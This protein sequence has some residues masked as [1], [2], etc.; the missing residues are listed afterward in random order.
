MRIVLILIGHELKRFANDKTALTL[1][2]LVPV[3]LI[4]IFG[5]VFGV[6]RSSSGPTGIP[7]AVVR[8]ADSPASAAILAALQ[9]EKAFKVITTQPDAKG[10]E[11]PLT[12]ARLRELMRS[13]S[14][15]FALIFPPDAQGDPVV[16][17]KL[18]FLQNPRNEVEAQTVT[19]LVQKTIFTSAPQALLA[20]LP[21][22][23]KQFIGEEGFDRFSRQL[24]KSV[25]AAFGGDEEE[26]RQK[27]LAG[28]F[29]LSPN[30]PSGGSGFPLGAGTDLLQSVLRI[31][32]EQVAGV[33]VK[34]PQATRNVGGWAMMFLLFSLTAAAGS[35]FAEKKAG[36]FQRLLAAPVRRTH[37]LW[38]KY[39]YGMLLGLVQLGALFLTGRILFGLDL[40]SNWHNLFLICLAASAACVAFG[41]LLAAISPTAAAANGLG[42][43]FIL[44]MS[45][46]GGAW[47]PTTFMPE[48]IQKLSKLTIVYWS[49][50][51][52]LQV[53]WA[54]CTT[55]ELL[56]ILG[57]LFGVAAV[58]N[59]FSVWRFNRGEMF[60]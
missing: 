44:T 39:L 28:Q 23:G 17:L 29:D 20:S 33:N 57:I 19:G 49:I 38:S 58:V 10:V 32:S 42:T 5:Q 47:F 11:Q 27:L 52:F 46:I 21:K 53:L 16:G 18:K 4:Y 34:N 9:K 3:M 14:P 15:R 22:L 26:V 31:D 48:F 1:T 59:A 54:G 51:G 37:I 45:A 40:T 56:P 35:L 30:A 6:G 12:E 55:Y 24:A 50:E 7:L 41:M 25:A 8:Q 43:F 36:L 13:G 2:F 60:E